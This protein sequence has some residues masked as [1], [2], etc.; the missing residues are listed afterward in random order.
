MGD[1]FMKIFKT[2]LL[3]TSIVVFIFSLLFN[4]AIWSSSYGSLIFK[5][6]DEKFSS[7]ASSQRLNFE[8]SYFVYKENCGVQIYMETET[9]TNKEKASYE[10]YFDKKGNVTIKGKINQIINKDASKIEY[11]YNDG[12][13]YINDNG[14]KNLQITNSSAV[15]KEHLTIINVLQDLLITDIETSKNKV[16]I[17]FSF[18]PFYVLGMKYTIKDEDKNISYKYDISGKL[19]EITINSKEE[20]S[21]YQINYKKSKI[22]LPNLEE[23][24]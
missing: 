6:D 4:V 24:K 2:I 9:K 15:S 23:Y 3:F 22:S 16:K 20:K 13:L 14:E 5:H 10:Y 19:R 17:D 1:K 7:L 8:P 11:Y 18:N 21:V 12:K